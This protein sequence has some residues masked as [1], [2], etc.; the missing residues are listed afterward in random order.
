[1]ACWALGNA[2]RTAL[3]IS[4]LATALAAHDEGL[5]QMKLAL[6][7]ALA[8]PGIGCSDLEGVLDLLSYCCLD[9]SKNASSALEKT[10]ACAAQSVFNIK[11]LKDW[12]SFQ[13]C[14]VYLDG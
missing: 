8:R 7:Y 13:T 4:E 1:M 9:F 5:T 11:A 12:G 14:S 3:A 10:R 2:N 6:D